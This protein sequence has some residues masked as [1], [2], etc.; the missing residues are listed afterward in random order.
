M[1][2]LYYAVDPL[3]KT[4]WLRMRGR[5]GRPG[6]PTMVFLHGRTADASQL[7]VPG[8]T[9]PLFR[10]TAN[11]GVQIL[12]LDAQGETWGN[13]TG[14]TEVATRHA[15]L[16]TVHGKS[17]AVTYVGYSMGTIVAM[18]FAARNPD[19]VARLVLIAPV[20][21]LDALYDEGGGIATGID[22]AYG[23]NWKTNGKAAGWDPVD[24]VDDLSGIPIEV[25]VGTDDTVIPE[26]AIAPWA[27]AHGDTTVNWYEG[28]NHVSV[29]MEVSSASLAAAAT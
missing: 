26:E 24:Q 20:F 22:G 23:G 3:L 16:P 17:G 7:V 5:K 14:M 19:K 9:E 2:A 12:S 29:M 27:A 18:N 28:A 10:R 1:T 25:H 4:G 6:G 15:Q 21:D 8:M 13:Q 11:R